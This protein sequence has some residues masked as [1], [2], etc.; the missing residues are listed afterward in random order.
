MFL[1]VSG[2]GLVK[3]QHGTCALVASSQPGTQVISSHVIQCVMCYDE[4]TNSY[5]DTWP[6]H[7]T[8]TMMSREGFLEEVLLELKFPG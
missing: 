2:A 3:V 7:Q 5:G 6:R 1:T 4:S 8:H